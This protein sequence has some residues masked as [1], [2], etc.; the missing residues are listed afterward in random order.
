MFSKDILERAEK[1]EARSL[2]YEKKYTDGDENALREFCRIDIFAM[3][4]SWVQKAIEQALM[5]GNMLPLKNLFT[6]GKIREKKH[7][8]TG[9]TQ[10]LIIREAVNR[11]AK[12]TGLPKTN[13]KYSYDSVY[14]KMIENKILTF[15]AARKLGPKT[16]LNH[17]SMAKNKKADIMIE[18]VMGGD[19]LR[20]GP[21]MLSMEGKPI[22]G[23][24]EI[25]FPADG[26]EPYF[27]ANGV[28]NIPY[29]KNKYDMLPKSWEPNN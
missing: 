5:T 13:P 1:R 25:F 3:K 10:G 14:T 20:C 28:F 4:T 12:E 15:D 6:T 26:R 19:V 24:F 29:E 27:N 17:C 21:T 23:I 22:F 8:V 2:E 18:N 7:S 11:E 16:I 9:K